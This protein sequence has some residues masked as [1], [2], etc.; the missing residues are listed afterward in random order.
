M[1]HHRGEARPFEAGQVIK[2][3]SLAIIVGLMTTMALSSLTGG[4]KMRFLWW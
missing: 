1:D 2:S 3:V 4:R